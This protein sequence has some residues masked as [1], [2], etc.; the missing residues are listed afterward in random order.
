MRATI[1]LVEDVV[2]AVDR[3]RRGRQE[4]SQLSRTDSIRRSGISHIRATAT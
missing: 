4:Q 1:D 2:A 3:L